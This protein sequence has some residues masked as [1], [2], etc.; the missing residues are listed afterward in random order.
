V[1][2]WYSAADYPDPEVR[3]RLLS[4]EAAEHATWRPYGYW[5]HVQ[6]CDDAAC[7]HR[8]DIED[9]ARAIEEVTA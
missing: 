1:T 9:K 3:A 4:A 2:D 6:T 7:T 8:D 5:R